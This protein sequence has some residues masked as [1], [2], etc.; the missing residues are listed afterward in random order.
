MAPASVFVGGKNLAAMSSWLAPSTWMAAT[1]L[2]RRHWNTLLSGRTAA[3]I[4]GGLNDACDTHVTVA[5]PKRAPLREVMTYMPFENIRNVFF[6]A[7]GSIAAPPRTPDR[8][9]CAFRGA[10]G[11]PHHPASRRCPPLPTPRSPPP[12]DTP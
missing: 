2:S 12:T 10:P 4:S 7:F 11:D 3:T 6:L 9:P 1:P 8:S 5:A